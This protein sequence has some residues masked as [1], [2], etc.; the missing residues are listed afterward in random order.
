MS[1]HVEAL[2][3]AVSIAGSQAKL[4]EAIA[5]F[6]DRP[7]F[8][9]QTVSYW[10]REQTLL[11][12]EWWPAIEHATSGWVTRSDLRPDVFSEAA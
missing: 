9:Q 11:S 4:A 1:T 8:K 5:Q 3:R 2:R 12:P 6:L 7:T 10:L